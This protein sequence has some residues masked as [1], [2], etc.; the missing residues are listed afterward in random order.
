[1]ICQK[2]YI[3]ILGIVFGDGNV[4]LQDI[5]WFCFTHLT[6]NVGQRSDEQFSGLDH[7][8]VFKTIPLIDAAVVASIFPFLTVIDEG[9]RPVE[10]L[11]DRVLHSF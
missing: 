9:V 11:N 5:F 1:M 6:Y 3:E 8:T 7:K 10:L 2:Q 4:H